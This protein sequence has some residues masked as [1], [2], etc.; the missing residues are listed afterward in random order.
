MDP[1]TRQ[2][3]RSSVRLARVPKYLKL[4]I[5]EITVTY[6][7]SAGIIQFVFGGGVA[8]ID[9]QDLPF[10]LELFDPVAVS[11][12]TRVESTRAPSPTGGG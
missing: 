9:D 8:A 11:F 3:F 4:D 5:D 7:D 6:V 1:N 10:G 12:S 2:L